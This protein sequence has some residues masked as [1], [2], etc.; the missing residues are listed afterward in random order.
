MSGSNQDSSF[1]PLVGYCDEGQ[2]IADGGVDYD[3]DPID[4][5]ECSG[6]AFVGP[7]D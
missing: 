4:P 5:S 2:P 7:S 1:G 6:E 3:P